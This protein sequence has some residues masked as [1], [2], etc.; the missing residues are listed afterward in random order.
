MAAG[1]VETGNPPR[2]LQPKLECGCG[3]N[4]NTGTTDGE[5]SPRSSSI[6]E[7][8]GVSM[9]MS[10]KLDLRCHC[11]APEEVLLSM[12][13]HLSRRTSLHPSNTSLALA[14][15]SKCVDDVVENVTRFGVYVGLLRPLILGQVVHANAL[16]ERVSLRDSNTEKHDAI[17]GGRATTASAADICACAGFVAVVP[18]LRAHARHDFLSRLTRLLLA[19]FQQGMQ[20]RKEEKGNN[21]GTGNWFV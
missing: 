15:V 13:R 4:G 11:V 8:K 7:F 18:S 5:V 12:T 2:I 17:L 16:P 9:V 1:K 6:N 19:V 21:M 3:G 10:K 20:E 14:A